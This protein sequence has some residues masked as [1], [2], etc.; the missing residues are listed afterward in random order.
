M[1]NSLI[2]QNILDV[3]NNDWNNF[4]NCHPN[5][6]VFQTTDYLH[7]H[8][9]QF[10]S[11]FFGYA[12]IKDGEIR[13]VISGVIFYNYFFPISCFTRRAIII[14]GPLID[15][16]DVIVCK[17]LLKHLIT[18]L[19]H[20]AIYIQFRNL[21]D[22]ECYRS[23]FEKNEFTYEPHLDILHDL[24]VD[25]DI[26][27]SKVSKNK[28]GNI[29]KTINKGLLFYEVTDGEEYKQCIDLVIQT[30]QRIGLP[31]FEKE[32]FLTANELLRGKGLLKTFAA[33]IDNHIIGTRMELCYKDMVYDWY[34]GADENFK[35]YY[36]NDFIPYHILLWSKENGYKI[37]D[38]GGAGKPNVP[39]G[40]RDHK[41]KFGGDL[42]EF[43]RFLY[44][45]HKILYKIGE[46][47]IFI[48][49]KII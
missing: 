22:M 34:A 16:N 8:T 21:W 31:C 49:K 26:I 5:A 12:A 47:G 43:G 28:R 6:T 23:I 17:A 44:V 1:H 3:N 48:K 13:G 35:N 27:K 4:V 30:Y 10:N 15:G 38:F 24:S 33:K 18:D 2:I 45:E 19:K 29:N 41:L 46:F 9:K 32:Y 14:G 36:P 25:F 7:L 42:I 40:V 11:K 37:F 39:Y 20:K